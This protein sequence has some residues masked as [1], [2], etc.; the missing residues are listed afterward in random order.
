MSQADSSGAH[1]YQQQGAQCC[2]P[3]RVESKRVAD[4]PGGVAS[5]DALIAIGT[6]LL[7]S[8]AIQFGPAKM[9]ASHIKIFPKASSD[10]ATPSRTSN[11]EFPASDA[12]LVADR[13][14]QIAVVRES[15]GA[16][17]SEPD[18]FNTLGILGYC[19]NGATFCQEWSSGHSGYDQQK[20]AAKLACRM[21]VPPT[22]CAQFHKSNPA[23]CQGCMQHC[24]SPITLGWKGQQVIN[25]VRDAEELVGKSADSTTHTHIGESDDNFQKCE[26]TV[27][28]PDQASPTVDTPENDREMIASLALLRPMEY[29]RVRKE[30]ARGLGIQLKT[31]DDLVTAARNEDGAAV[32]LPFSEIEPHPE[33]IN[34]A[35]VLDEVVEIILRYVVMDKEQA[36][37]VALWAAM[38]WFIDEVEVAAIAIITAPEKACGKS[39]LLTILGYMVARPLPAANSTA[40]FLFRAIAAW[41]PTILIDE[42]DTF[43]RENDELKGLV[44]AGHTRANAY[45]GRTVA[46]GDGHEPKL[47]DVWGAKAFAGIALEKHLPDATMSR[48]IVFKLRRKMAHETVSRLRH[49]DRKEFTNI[50]AKLARFSDDFS[51]QVRQARPVLPD[52]LS[53][54]AQDNWEPLLAIAECAGPDWVERGTVAA[55]VLSRTG[56]ESVSTGNEL[57]SDIQQVFETERVERIRTADLITALTEDDEKPW[58]TYNRGKPLSPRQLAKQLAGYGIKSKTVRFAHDTPK[59]YEVSQ[60]KDAF[61][62]YLAAPPPLPPQRN[63]W[64]EPSGGM[65]GGDADHTKQTRIDAETPETLPTLESEGVADVS[66]DLGEIPKITF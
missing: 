54:R 36:D 13:C 53:D 30:R 65:A 16:D 31:L 35:Q 44:N 41:R 45:V 14:K 51:P 59:G 37:A 64:P 5:A 43:I 55:L 39:Q 9:S 12:N 32:H 61:A 50:A 40:S 52:E 29:D 23:G 46:I 63:E 48:G 2:H 22:T 18:W 34:P 6:D 7:A 47:F 38:T 57:L 60:F 24:N 1:M 4:Q 42:A 62:R 15:R 33:P 3:D 21:K 56:E 19:E 58:N 11:D 25:D 49:A 28:R 20:T 26:T 66:P 8:Q 17:Q 10:D 27:I